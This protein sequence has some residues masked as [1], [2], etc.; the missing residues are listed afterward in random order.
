MAILNIPNCHDQ[1]DVYNQ[2]SICFSEENGPLSLN[3]KTNQENTKNI[4]LN[5]I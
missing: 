1:I 3:K 2:T 5:L 4:H